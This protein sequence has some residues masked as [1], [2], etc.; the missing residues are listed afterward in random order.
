MCEC[1]CVCVSVW[2]C[3]SL[4]CLHTH[5]DTH[6]HTLSWCH[7]QGHIESTTSSHSA[8]GFYPAPQQADPHSTANEWISVCV[9]VH[10]CVFKKKKK[11]DRETTLICISVFT[12]NA[13]QWRRVCRRDKDCLHAHQGTL[14]SDDVTRK[15]WC[16]VYVPWQ[17]ATVRSL[18]TALNIFVK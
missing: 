4:P 3:L 8:P 6:T 15:L 14:T 18:P 5:T 1:V 10:A 12:T 17:L 9:C 13:T 16:G 2:S 11:W 7:Q